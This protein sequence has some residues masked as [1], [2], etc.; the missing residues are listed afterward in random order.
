MT[1]DPDNKL[2]DYLKFI[3]HQNVCLK[4]FFNTSGVMSG[5]TVLLEPSPFQI[6]LLEYFPK[7]LRLYGCKALPGIF[8]H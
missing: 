5:A 3:P 7:W 8:H 6:A 2:D 4:G 1:K